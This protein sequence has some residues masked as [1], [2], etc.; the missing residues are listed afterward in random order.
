MNFINTTLFG[1]AETRLKELP[2]KSVQ[3]C[4][5]SPPYYGLRDYGVDGQIGLEETPE[6]YIDR[7]VRV[8]KEVKRAL[9]DDGT[10]WVNIGDSYSG[11]GKGG[12][13][14]A[15]KAVGW[16][17]TYPD[18]RIIQG[19]KPK[20][21][22]GIPWRLAF[23]LQGFAVVPFHTFTEWANILNEAQKTQDWELVKMVENQI[24]L[25]DLMEALKSSGWYLRS[26]IIWNKPNCM[27]ESV[28]DRPTKSHEYIFILSKQPKYFYNSGAISEPI[29]PS[30]LRDARREAPTGKRL[31]RD[32]PGQAQNG[33]G[34]LQ[35]YGLKRNKRS[36]WDMTLKPYSEAHYAVFSPELPA[37]CIKAGSREGDIVLDP[38][39]GSG[40][41]AEVAIRL[42][43]KF[44][45]VDLDQR[46]EKL[47]NK[48]I[49]PLK[50]GLFYNND[51][52]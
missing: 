3:M 9:K 44:I 30:S 35:N 15:K 40:T 47:I 34:Y 37:T 16:Q 8:F 45:G 27:P 2:E 52:V 19:L 33:G 10:L 41:T 5:T 1:D 49:D 7:L 21:L 14:G 42:G 18:T 36:V 43:R 20:N 23:A 48:R 13:S 17:P 31:Q 50:N 6:D 46:N 12:Q 28:K 24:R 22:I 32:Y 11:S 25:M 39:M 26:D 51:E 29:S 4:V 38:F